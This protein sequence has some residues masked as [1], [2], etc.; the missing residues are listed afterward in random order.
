MTTS[1][2]YP[3]RIAD[4]QNQGWLTRGDGIYE[5]FDQAP[6]EPRPLAE[7]EREFGPWRPVLPLLEGDRA[8]LV[9]AFDIAG[10]KMITSVASALEQVF[11]EARERA[12]EPGGSLGTDDYRYA[13]RTLTAGRPGSWEASSVIGV[14]LFGNEL[15]LYPY[16]QGT[17]VAT[18]RAT[19][20]HPKR[21]NIEAKD[22]IEHVLRRW[23]NSPDR[24]TEVPETLA[25]VIS[26]Y[27]DDLYEEAGWSRIADQWLQPGGLA[28][29]NFGRCYHLLYS[30][31][32]HFDPN[33]LA[34]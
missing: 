22:R 4:S 3:Y 5:G 11:H 6:L 13:V 23:T 12:V 1:E 27:A 19:G 30:T 9:A 14:V 24:Y 15:N 10:R 2:Q 25:A 34:Y 31:S 32:L 7:I 8:E 16:K 20:P 21:V 17:D 18:M 33:A 29:E 28:Q 26:S